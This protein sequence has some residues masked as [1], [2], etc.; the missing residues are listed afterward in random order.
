[1]PDPEYIENRY[2][3]SYRFKVANT[4]FCG[5]RRSSMPPRRDIVGR[6]RTF[7]RSVDVNLYLIN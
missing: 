7:G 3:D 2:K 4:V 1:M 6:C 5:R